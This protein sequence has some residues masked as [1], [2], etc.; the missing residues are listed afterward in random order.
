LLR[1]FRLQSIASHSSHNRLLHYFPDWNAF[2]LDMVL[3]QRKSTSNETAPAR[4]Q[5]FSISSTRS[6][7]ST[8]NKSKKINLQHDFN[9]NPQD[10]TA[11]HEMLQENVNQVQQ[12]D[13]DQQPIASVIFELAEISQLELDAKTRD[14]PA[15]HETSHQSL[16]QVPQPDLDQQ[17]TT[18]LIFEPTEISQN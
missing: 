3:M 11:D 17:P 16:N 4:F 6:V 9:V 2:V 8:S 18:S 7:K 13:L 14:E 10:G 5:E 15:D 1:L 12:Q